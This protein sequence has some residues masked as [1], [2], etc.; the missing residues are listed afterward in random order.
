MKNA[1][2]YGSNSWTEATGR[3]ISYRTKGNKEITLESRSGFPDKVMCD[4]FSTGHI[5]LEGKSSLA[6]PEDREMGE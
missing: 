4:P 2:K 3:T 1:K 5:A 6:K